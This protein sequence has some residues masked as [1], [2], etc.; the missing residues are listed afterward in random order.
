[1]FSLRDEK[2]KTK[3][4]LLVIEIIFIIVGM[5]SILK[6][7]NS[8]L[9][10]SLEKFDNDDV[11][12]IRS[13]WN[14]IDNKI[15]SYENIK[16]STVYIMPG[17]TFVL[18]FFMMIF[19]KMQGIVAF[20]IFQLI[21]QAGSIY[22]IFLIGRKVF[23]SRVGLIASIIDVIYV[24]ELFVV[25]TILMEC[26]CKFL[27][28]LLIYISIYA[29]KTKSSKLYIAGGIIW[30]IS[31]L[32]KPTMA[33]Y[34]IVI[35][36]MWIKS[37][38]KFSE[39]L[40]YTTLV[41]II[42]CTIMSPWWVRNYKE[43]NS[44]I[45]FT[46]STGNP[47]LQGTFINYDDSEGWGVPY[48]K[49]ENAI[50]NDQNEIK[51]GLQRLQKYGAEQPIKY[52]FWYTIGK[53]FF[54]WRGPFYWRTIFNIPSLIAI[55]IH[56]IILLLGI[57]GIVKAS[58]NNLNVALVIGVVLLLNLIYLPFYTFERYSYMA[59]PLVMLFA[60]LSIDEIIKK[61]RKLLRWKRTPCL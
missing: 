55:S 3:Y 20:K 6:Y 23:S 14:L 39:I 43:F 45:P 46:K 28:L 60:A 30:A 10:G 24:P 8:L 29:I 31:C 54:F 4:S 21:L 1:M 38:Y 52:I 17:L 9:L 19:G 37:K 53:T 42:F 22:L 44:V 61:K 26:I 11:K 7:G 40:K 34:P 50:K 36:F 2:K 47:F 32:F 51:A 27:F 5:I 25:N 13:A 15:L 57:L 49:S 33:G 12:Y 16:E 56:V 48:V 59:M 58:K 18:A 35:L 41:L